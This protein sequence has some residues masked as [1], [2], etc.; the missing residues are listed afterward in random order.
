MHQNADR[1]AAYDGRGLCA[2]II[3]FFVIV[4]ICGQQVTNIN[5]FSYSR[6]LFCF[7]NFC[8]LVLFS[9]LILYQFRIPVG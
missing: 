6:N 7:G 2:L 9:F 1:R 4:V 5:N 3:C 8:L